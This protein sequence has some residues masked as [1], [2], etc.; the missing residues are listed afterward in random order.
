M[1]A[2]SFLITAALWRGTLP[3]VQSKELLMK[4]IFQTYRF[5]VYF[6]DFLLTLQIKIHKM[7][8]RNE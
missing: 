8:V 2:V 4:Q 1:L 5:Y 6:T 3:A 7:D